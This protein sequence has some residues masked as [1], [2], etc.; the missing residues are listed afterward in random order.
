MNLQVTSQAQANMMCHMDEIVT[1]GELI[2]EEDSHMH[3]YTKKKG[4]RGSCLKKVI[5]HL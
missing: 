1:I 2:Y 3:V 5:E 4:E